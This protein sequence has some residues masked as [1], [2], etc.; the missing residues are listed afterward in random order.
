[1]DRHPPGEGGHL[2]VPSS[3]TRWGHDALCAP[4]VEAFWRERPPADLC[5]LRDLCVRKTASK[6]RKLGHAISRNWSCLILD[7]FGTTLDLRTTAADLGFAASTRPSYF[8]P[9]R[10]MRAQLKKKPSITRLLVPCSFYLFTR[11][12]MALTALENMLK[13]API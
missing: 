12:A 7:D 3:S 5:H 2:R 9:A 11:S 4:V 1:M 13:E 6:H 10:P 8:S